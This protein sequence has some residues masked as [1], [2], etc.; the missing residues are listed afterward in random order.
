[1]VANKTIDFFC[2]VCTKRRGIN[3]ETLEQVLTLALE[4][5]HEGREGQKVGTLF[6]ISDAEQTMRHSRPLM[7][8]PLLLHPDEV[9]H[10]NDPNLRETVKELATL[11]GAFIVN[12]GG[13]VLSACRYINATSEGVTLPLGLGSRHMAAASITRTTNAVAVVVSEST[14]V[15]VFDD[16]EI[17][18]EI[19]PEEWLLSRYSLH[20]TGPV[21][22]CSREHITIISKNEE[23]I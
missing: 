2:G 15:R 3:L 17:V 16:G 6:V 12:D 14:I 23:G 8:D 5:A 20:L 10:L 9:K 11:D 22:T 1:M 7:L 19:I 18:S 21:S 4:I 13:I